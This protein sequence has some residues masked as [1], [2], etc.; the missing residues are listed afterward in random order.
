LHP[1]GV[2]V[3]VDV[4]DVAVAARV[5]RADVGRIRLYL[6]D[7]NVASNPPE[8]IAITQVARL[9]IIA[10]APCRAARCRASWARRPRWRSV[11]GRT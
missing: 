9:R 10:R 8:A 5:W 1:T 2:E 6:L 7:T 11:R 4:A 3:V